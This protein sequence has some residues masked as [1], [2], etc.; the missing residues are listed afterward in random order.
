LSNKIEIYL[1]GS[2]RYS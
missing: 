2:M 1:I